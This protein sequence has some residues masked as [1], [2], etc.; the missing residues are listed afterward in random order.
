MAGANSDAPEWNIGRAIECVGKLDDIFRMPNEQSGAHLVLGRWTN[1]DGNISSIFPTG[2]E[3][4]QNA[5]YN[6][7]KFEYIIIIIQIV[8]GNG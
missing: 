8:K 4:G 2:T 7:L 3:Y 5:L 6:K 1:D